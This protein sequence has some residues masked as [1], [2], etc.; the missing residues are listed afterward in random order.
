MKTILRALAIAALATIVS[1]PAVASPFAIANVSVK[2][3]GA[4]PLPCVTMPDGSLA[5]PSDTIFTPSKN[6]AGDFGRTEKDALGNTYGFAHA[7]LASRN[8][9]AKCV[10]PEGFVATPKTSWMYEAPPAK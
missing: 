1:V 4:L 5:I 10:I 8:T 6:P 2:A 9:S 7:I 3:D